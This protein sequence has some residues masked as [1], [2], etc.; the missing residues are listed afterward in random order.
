MKRSLPALYLS[1]SPLVYVVTQVRFSAVVSVEKFVPDIQEKLRHL[2]FP[3]FLRSQMPEISFIM[4]ESAPKVAFMPRFEFQNKEGSLGIV[5]TSNNFAIHT[6]G[7]K[8]YEDF[9]KYIATAI[10][11]INGAMSLSIVERI[12]L[13]Y[14]DLVRLKENETWK[15]YLKEGLL[16]LDPAKVGVKSWM[17]KFESLG[18]TEIGKL[19]IRCGQTELP[20]PPDLQPPTLKYSVSLNPGEIGTLLDCD[21]FSETTMDFESKAVLAKIGD[22]HD[23]IDRAFR[24]S[25]TSHALKTWGGEE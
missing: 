10:E 4:G 14:V 12:G 22:L 8:T 15:H 19:L 17:S 5:L 7:Y 25:V 21:H 1:K 18:D 13:R 24:N 2:G 11:V 20:L 3:R 23:H 6:N 16:G 9:E